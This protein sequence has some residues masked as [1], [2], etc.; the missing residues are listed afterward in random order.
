LQIAIISA[1]DVPRRSCPD[2]RE[3]GVVAWLQ[4]FLPLIFGL[5]RKRLPDELFR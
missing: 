1:I 5:Y 4:V 2:L 3:H